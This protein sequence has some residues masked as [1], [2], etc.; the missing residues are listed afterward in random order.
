MKLDFYIDIYFVINFTMDVILLILT[1]KICKRTNPI[2]RILV[3]AVIGSVCACIVAISAPLPVILSIIVEHVFV[4][5]AMILIAFRYGSRAAFIRT[6]LVFL[7]ITFI[8]GGVMQSILMNLG[9]NANLSTLYDEVISKNITITLLVILSLL[10]TPLIYY[11][12]HVLRE[13]Q[14]LSQ[15]L[16]DINMYFNEVDVMA[17]KG[18]MDTGNCLKDPI[19][20]WP[21]IVVDK[22]LLYEKFMNIQCSRP[23]S[24][25]VIPYVSVGKEHGMLYGIRM[26]KVIIKNAQ[27]EV[28]TRNVVAAL[29]EYGFL[30]T[31]EYRA[32]LHCDLLGL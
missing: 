17:C 14:Q 20:G 18:F 22:D 8:L 7:L 27:E 16:Y 10:L 11:G 9:A 5:L 1:K 4:S 31:K 23:E 19:R 13:N 29:S 25:C 32:L 21:V 2:R 6:Y 28:C 30:N 3:A 24:I 12:Y 15:G 26:E